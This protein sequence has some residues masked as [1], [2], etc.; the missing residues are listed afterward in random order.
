[1]QKQR[2]TKIVSQNCQSEGFTLIEVLLAMAIL[3]VVVTVIYTVFS[4]SSANAERAES[5]RDETDLART[6][7]SRMSDDIANAYCSTGAVGTFF[8]G[9]N[10]EV[11]TEGSNF[12]HDS[13][14]LT[15]LTNWRKPDSKETDLWEVGYSF[16]EKSDGSG[17]VLVRRE[18]RELNK[19]VPPLEGGVEYE[20][21]DRIAELQLR[22]YDGTN[23]VDTWDRK[24]GCSQSNLP[25]AV[26]ISLT[27][28]DGR[29][30]KTQV[31]HERLAGS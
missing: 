15:T 2:Q 9:K 30:F 11:E 18:K 6:L 4:T 10:E 13:F 14:S 21:T 25:R 22:Y 28:D 5:I 29:V 27:L 1:M 8:Y 16:K 31:L 24:T 20:I 7:M 17:Y 3:A 12:R 26:E 23:W 19:D